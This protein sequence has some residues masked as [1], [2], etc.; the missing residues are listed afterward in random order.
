MV[1]P[2]SRWKLENTPDEKEIIM[3]DGPHH[4][5]SFNPV[6]NIQS[7][8]ISVSYTHL[9]VYKRQRMDSGVWTQ[10]GHPTVTTAQDREKC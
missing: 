6:R 1:R 2:S 10:S 3:Q 9:D 5:K 4:R 7:E 8:V